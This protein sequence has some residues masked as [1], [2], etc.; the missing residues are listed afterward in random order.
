MEA[1]EP[2]S[3]KIVAQLFAKFHARYGNRWASNFPGEELQRLAVAEWG[4]GL[5]GITP[6]QLRDG[7]NAW[8]HDWP[9]CLPEFRRACLG[10]SKP[11]CNEDWESLGRRLGVYPRVGE[12][13]PA[14]KSRVGR[15]LRDPR[16]LNPQLSGP[17]AKVIAAHGSE[18]LADQ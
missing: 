1:L 11:T 18:L 6:E 17:E 4:D 15:N 13:W 3:P 7:L 8:D 12:S 10:I 5:A 2:L 16:R 9:P 14:F